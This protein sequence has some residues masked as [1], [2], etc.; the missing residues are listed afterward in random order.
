MSMT[1]LTHISEEYSWNAGL[2]LCTEGYGSLLNV[3]DQTMQNVLVRM[4]FLLSFEK[5]MWIGLHDRGLDITDDYYWSNCQPLQSHWTNWDSKPLSTSN[6]LCVLLSQRS[7][8]WHTESCWKTQSI[9]CAKS[10]GTCTYE[11]KEKQ[12]CSLDV[13]KKNVN[14][15]TLVGCEELC[16][17]DVDGSNVCWAYIFHH[18]DNTCQLIFGSNPFFC[19]NDIELNDDHSFGIRRCFNFSKVILVDAADEQIDSPLLTCPES[20]SSDAATTTF[21]TSLNNDTL[22]T[23]TFDSTVADMSSPN[24]STTVSYIS[25]QSTAGTPA[26][27]TSTTTRSSSDTSTTGG[28]SRE[29]SHTTRSSSYTSTTGGSSRETSHTTRSSSDT[30]TTGGPSRETSHTTRSSSHTSTTGGSSRETGPTTRSSSDTSTTGSFRET[31]Q[32]TRSSPVTST[33]GRSFPQTSTIMRFSSDTT[34]TTKAYSD[35]TTTVRSSSD[36]ATPPRSFS[37]TIT[38]G[39]SFPDTSNTAT[40]ASST[41]AMNSTPATTGLS[42]LATPVAP[43]EPVMPRANAKCIC[44]CLNVNTTRRLQ[45]LNVLIENLLL[46]KRNLSA[47]RRK[48]GSAGDDR[49]SAQSLGV[50]GATFLIFSI[51]FVLAADLT[52]VFSSRG[53]DP[54]R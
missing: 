45:S 27:R 16:N 43:K 9:L 47:Y 51:L 37:D 34:T 50:G 53:C 40:Y 33:T 44:M 52:R 25:D 46:D 8:T 4:Q 10:E 6:K 30:S 2:D 12:T 32:T 21:I 18:Q 3:M 22:A 19:E 35:T 36:T 7:L 20:T 39:R 14:A 38:S 41:S 54:K 29:T 1:T 15:A 13:P 26:P 11:L 5:D 23:T 48:H 28:S 17:T 24:T 31:S 42:Q 49:P